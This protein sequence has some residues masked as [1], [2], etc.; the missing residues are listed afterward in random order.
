MTKYKLAVCEIHNP[1]IHGTD[2]TSDPNSSNH[3]LIETLYDSED[4]FDEIGFIDMQ[5]H[6]NFLKICQHRV[7][8]NHPTIR[9][10]SKIIRDNKY[11]KCEIVEEDRLGGEESVGY[12]KTF[13]LKIVQRKWKKVFAERK[14]VLKKR[15][16]LRALHYR[17]IHGK[18]PK[19]CQTYPKFRLF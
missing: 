19:D 1:F 14:K 4:F 9:N 8:S 11:M 17:E 5:S 2:Y 7:H 13:W 16:S 3:F 18:W 12:I 15:K 10:Y 6:L